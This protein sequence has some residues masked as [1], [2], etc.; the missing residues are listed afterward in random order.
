MFVFAAIVLSGLTAF[1]LETELDFV[2]RHSSH[3]PAAVA[4]WMEH[5]RDGVHNTNSVYPFIMYGIDWLAFAHIVIAL[6]FIGPYM[7]PLRNKW[8]IDWGITCCVLVFPLALIAGPVRGIPFF[9]QLVDCS[10]GFFGFFPLFIIRRKI[11][12]L[13]KLMS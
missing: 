6:L 12:K 7:D 9:H 4:D 10:F 13:E 5:V 3:L 1:P 8:V 2:A 11:R